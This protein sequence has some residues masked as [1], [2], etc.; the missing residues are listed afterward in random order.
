MPPALFLTAVLMFFGTASVP[1]NGIIC[2]TVRVCA[3]REG[4]PKLAAFV[5][6]CSQRLGD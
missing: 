3:N 5:H 1:I 6:A 2:S 4:Q